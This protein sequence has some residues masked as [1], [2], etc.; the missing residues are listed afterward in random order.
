M[1]PIHGLGASKK[2][3]NM[4]SEDEL[5]ALIP[6][7]H[8]CWS[9]YPEKAIIDGTVRQV[10]FRVELYGTCLP[11]TRYADPGFVRCYE[12]WAALKQ[13]AKWIMPKVPREFECEVE[14]FDNAIHYS[15]IRRNRGD[16]E[17]HIR[18]VHQSGFNAGDE[19]A[20]DCL[21]GITANLSLLGVAADNWKQAV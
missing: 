5:K 3:T 16:V 8:V 20:I 15:G 19:S 10:G 17:L 11:E 1:A 18:I 7:Y 21:R 9:S 4:N 6:R 12:V 2:G 13:V 14:I